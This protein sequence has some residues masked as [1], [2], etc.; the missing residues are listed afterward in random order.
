M[1]CFGL[2]INTQDRVLAAAHVRHYRRD[3]EVISIPLKFSLNAHPLDKIVV[4]LAEQGTK[5]RLY[6]REFQKTIRVLTLIVVEFGRK[7]GPL[8][9]TRTHGENCQQQ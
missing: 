6:S 8:L 7:R 9:S 2:E 5:S 1:Q 4:I 3:A